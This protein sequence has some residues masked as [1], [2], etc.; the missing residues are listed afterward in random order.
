MQGE[1][2]NRDDRESPVQDVSVEELVKGAQE[3]DVRSFEGIYQMFFDRIY[4]YVSLKLGNVA[5]A[6][7]V[8]EDVF[9]KV[10]ESIRTFRWKGVPFS[11]WLFRIAHNLVVDHLRKRSRERVV[12]LEEVVVTSSFDMDE[13]VEIKL[14]M[15][16]VNGAMESLTKA[17]NEVITLRFAAGLSL[18][19]TA[20]AV[21]KNENAV[22]AL[23]HAGLL[24][25][26]RIL[27][28]VGDDTTSKGASS[29]YTGVGG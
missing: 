24:K 27:T 13:H 17:Q 28:P 20:K 6:E 4:R 25:L 22:K 9:V 23:Q 15:V 3:G 10:L 29:G 12:P 18:S 5:E 26:R 14:A 11:S 1:Q 19:E 16:Q 2:V 21:G 8:T 7:D